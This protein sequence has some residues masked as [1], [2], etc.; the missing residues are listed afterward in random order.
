[1]MK[2][3]TV[4]GYTRHTTEPLSKAF[5]LS[6]DPEIEDVLKRI[7]HC[8]GNVDESEFVKKGSSMGYGKYLCSEIRY[9]PL[10]IHTF[11]KLQG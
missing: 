6:N 1:M 7:M 8:V 10:M 2:Q 3:V 5:E 11:K 4:D 9:T